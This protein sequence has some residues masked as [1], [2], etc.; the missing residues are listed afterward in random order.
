[1][2]KREAPLVRVMFERYAL[3]REGAR[4]LAMW[5][6][7]QGHRT[8]Q[9]RPWSH[10]SVLTVLRN[11]AYVGE[12]FFR[13]THYPGTH[14]SIVDR[15]L[16]DTASALLADRAGD[17]TK[18]AAQSPDYLLGGLVVCQHCGKRFVGNAAHGNRYRYRYYTC[19]SRHRYG[20]K[21]CAAERL[22]A[23]ELDQ[24][25]L[26]A[27]MTLYD[28]SELFT[29]A[30]SSA[31]TRQRKQRKQWQ[32]EL[33]TV[34]ADVAKAEQAVERYL[35]AF[36]NG[37]L[38]E[39]ACADRVRTLAAKIAQLRDRRAELA[40]L[41][42]APMPQAPSASDL[43]ALRA[44]IRRAVT[45]GTDEDRKR[46]LQ[47]LVHEIRVDA[48]ATSSR[49]S[50]TPRASP[51][52]RFAPLKIWCPRQD[53]NLRPS[54]PEADALSPELRGRGSW[55]RLPTV[56]PGRSRPIRRRALGWRRQGDLGRTG[57]TEW[58]E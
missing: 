24:A 58:H 21:T 31:A 43:Q 48:R 40:E 28:G 57:S 1:M 45:T 12:V 55:R 18:R 33:A 49:C 14:E 11:R 19:F 37:S 16:F 34:D 35:L 9:G 52:R 36:E 46:L 2:N 50:K 42:D 4:A 44:E 23:G 39:A 30:V 32:A 56:T 10:T 7:E 22:P 54:A 41:L 6:N 53:S 51:R 8:K 47:A 15:D 5:L 26:D 13:G 29:R 3:Q 25:V 27:L 38:P 20:T 17:K